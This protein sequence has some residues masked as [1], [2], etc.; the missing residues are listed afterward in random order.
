MI[1]EMQLLDNIV[2]Q[3]QKLSAEYRLRLIQRVTETLL[4]PPS[5]LQQSQPLQFGKYS[6]GRM[7]TIEDFVIAEW[8]PSG[9]ELNGD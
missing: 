6:E 7:S 8:R 4:K 9:A 1:A 5:M 2:I 3:V